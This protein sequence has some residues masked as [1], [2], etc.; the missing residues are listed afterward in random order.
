MNRLYLPFLLAL[1]FFAVPKES[2]AQY[3]NF[4][5][6]SEVTIVVA[7]LESAAKELGLDETEIEDHFLDLLRSKLPGLLV[8]DS[9]DSSVWVLVN[10]ARSTAY[11][12][13]PLGYFGSVSVG[14]RRRVIIMNTGKVTSGYLWYETHSITGATSNLNEH[15]RSVLDGLLTSFATA[16]DQDNPTK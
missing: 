4:T 8:Q 9:A 13:Y 3:G 5:D 11:Q 6:L 12:G 14:V 15:V 10:I 7:T 16:W 1:F 2:V